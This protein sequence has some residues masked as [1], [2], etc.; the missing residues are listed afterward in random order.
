[1]GRVFTVPLWERIGRYG[2]I[3]A[4]DAVLSAAAFR[5]AMA[6]RFEEGVPDPWAARLWV[7]TALVV[8][9]RLVANLAGRLHRWSFRRADLADAARL[10][11]A[12]VAGSALVVTLARW[13]A[14]PGVPPTVHALEFFLSST[15]FALLRFGPRVALLG[16]SE[17]RRR[18]SAAPALVVGTSFAAESLARELRRGP[19]GRWEVVGFVGSDPDEIGRRIDGTPVVGLM[20]D[21]GALVSRH[22]ARDVLLAIPRPAAARLRRAIA[23]CASSG[24]RFRIVPQSASLAEPVSAAMLDDL[25]PEDLLERAPVE[26]DR[27]E[28]RR[29]VAG[30]SVLV[31]GAGLEIGG[32]ACRQLAHLGVRQ[33]VMVD[34]DADRLERRARRLAAERPG[35]DLR[36]E[37][38]DLA[39]A[40]AVAYLGR[41]CHPR[42]V[43]HAAL[44]EAV[45]SRED[46]PG[47]AFRRDVLGTLHLARMARACGAERLVLASREAHHP[48]RTTERVAER[49]ARG[50][51]RGS[52]TRATVV[53]FGDVLGA[54]GSA[55]PRFAEQVARGGPVTVTH[56]ECTRRFLTVPEAAGLLLAAGLG[57]GGELCVLDAGAPVRMDEL[58]RLAI[59][60]AGGA[61]PPGVGIVYTGPRD[62]EP[63]RRS[64]SAAAAGAPALVLAPA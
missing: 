51:T 37:L 13:L 56:P 46:Q 15:G 38:A 23:A 34:A 5:A 59:A 12:C 45:A 27:T 54:G 18:R 55:V 32:E 10:A 17:V 6:L 42:Y 60:L 39:D 20:H 49:V 24:V 19:A 16:W 50:A 35:L 62:G 8:A 1:M 14:P 57:D 3:L 52:P 43:L 36:A 64:G 41:R 9:S 22:A 40:R 7:A 2:I 53:R 30:A 29:R 44:G 21:L 47:E 48:N 25:A 63:G 28:L 61:A 4:V 26:L 33:L 58:A 31:T 11:T